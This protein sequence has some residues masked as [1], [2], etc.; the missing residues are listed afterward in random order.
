MLFAYPNR[1]RIQFGLYETLQETTVHL[2]DEPFQSPLDAG[3]GF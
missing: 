1:T 2:Y 3:K